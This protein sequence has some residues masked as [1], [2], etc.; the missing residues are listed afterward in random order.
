M[1]CNC[2]GYVAV[3]EEAVSVK[4]STDVLRTMLRMFPLEEKAYKPTG[5]PVGW[6][7]MSEFVDTDGN[8]FHKG[9]EQ[10]KLKGTL[11]PTKVKPRKKTKRRTREQILIDR[12]NKKKVVLREARKKKMKVVNERTETAN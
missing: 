1:K 9:K 10:P 6:H 3:D 2:G 12:H 8:V 5:R 4:C 11:L 7:W